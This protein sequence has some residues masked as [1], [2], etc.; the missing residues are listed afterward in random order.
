MAVQCLSVEKVLDMSGGVCE[1]RHENGS[2]EHCARVCHSFFVLNSVTM[3]PQH[4]K[5]FS[6]PLEMLQCQEHKPLIGT[7]YFMKAEPLF[8]M[9][10]AAD[11]HQQHGQVTSQHVQ[12]N[13]FH[14]IVD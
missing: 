7:K 9:S 2:T 3:P 6:R 5:N 12:Q 8:K 1:S 13:L 11:D 4:M 14:T 10:N